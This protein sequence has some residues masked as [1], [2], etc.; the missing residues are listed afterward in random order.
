MAYLLLVENAKQLV[1]VCN[2]GELYKSGEAQKDVAIIEDGALVV[3]L[4]GKIAAVG[5]TQEIKQQFANATFRKVI[6]AKNQCILPGF[7]DSHTHPVWSG[8]RCHEFAKKLAGAT[9]MDIHKAGG[10]IGF[11]VR[12]CKEASEEELAE[13]L[14]ARLDRMLRLGTTLVEAKSGYGLELDTEVK[15]LKVLHEVNKTHPIDL[16]S[17]YL[18]AHSIP[19]GSTAEAATHDIVHNQIPELKKLI[20]AD[21]IS[22]TLIDVF[23]EKNFF[24]IDQTRE[25]LLAGKA[26][27]LESN[28]HGDEL[29]PIKAAELAGEIGALAMTHC[30]EV[31]DEG[32]KAMSLRPTFAI[33]LPVT[34]FL[35]KLKYPP[36]RKMIEA[37]VPVALASDFNP[38]AH[39]LSL[40]YVMNLACVNMGLT[41]EEALVAATINS[42]AS[43]GKSK[44]YG[45]LEPGKFA[46]F[47]VLDAP[48]WEHVIYELVD[49]PIVTVVKK[50]E[51]AW[52]K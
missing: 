44:E 20:E 52:S 40:P 26:I 19:Q 13:L 24:S 25:I 4:E 48:I 32:I 36:A 10:G 27:G 3:D 47:F 49:T 41:M 50:G 51:V 23:C 5:T 6:D 7:V 2:K 1:L 12:H 43:I 8:D 31:S 45:S 42:A 29:T 9:Y 28:F 14:K 30:E 18:A 37:N 34:A 38:N 39:C 16:V 33:L 21:V 11:T 15:L 35:L 46:D 17:N 22:P